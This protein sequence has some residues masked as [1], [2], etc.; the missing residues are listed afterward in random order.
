VAKENPV[1]MGRSEPNNSPWLPPPDGRFE[2]SA[3]PF[4][5]F[6]KI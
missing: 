3:N 4:S 5:L 1:G 2:W 6:V